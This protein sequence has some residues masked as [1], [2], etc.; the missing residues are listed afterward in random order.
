[1]LSEK[2]RVF[3]K[4][5]KRIPNPPGEIPIRVLVADGLAFYVL[6]P[7]LKFRF[8]MDTNGYAFCCQPK[9]PVL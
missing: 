6:I 2:A 8:L 9:L 3:L 7:D 1:M 5:S 4:N